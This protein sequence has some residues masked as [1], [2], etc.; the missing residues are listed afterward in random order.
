[1]ATARKNVITACTQDEPV[2]GQMK[3][4]PVAVAVVVFHCIY[5]CRPSNCRGSLVQ[6]WYENIL[7]STAEK[8]LI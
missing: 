5:T 3:T 7:I 4:L 2:A 6:I 8:R 1:M